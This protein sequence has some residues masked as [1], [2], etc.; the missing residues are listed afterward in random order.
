MI[1]QQSIFA[2]SNISNMTVY[3]DLTTLNL[4]NTEN[5]FDILNKKHPKIEP[6]NNKL[7]F[8]PYQSKWITNYK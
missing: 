2:I 6:K 4:I 8:L 1:K 5:W 3:L 7:K